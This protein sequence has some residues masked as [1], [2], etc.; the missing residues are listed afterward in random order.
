FGSASY[1]AQAMFSRAWGE[2]VLPV[3]LAAPQVELPPPPAP[4]GF[5]GVG[6]W[7]TSAEFKDIKVT[8]GGD[9]LFRSDFSSKLEGWK[10][11]AGNWDVKDGALR[12]TDEQREARITAGDGG[13]QDYALS[14]KARK[15]GGSEGFLVLF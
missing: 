7:H 2:T 4:Q 10:P 8:H 11:A 14:L 12:Q 9:T 13:W 5:V 6:T 1:Y 3:E 15:L